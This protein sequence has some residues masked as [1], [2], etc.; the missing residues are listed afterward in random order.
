MDALLTNLIALAA[1][2][3]TLI[4]TPVA[5]AKGADV[6]ARIKA[7]RTVLGYAYGAKLDDITV[8]DVL[9][10]YKARKVT[11]LDYGTSLVVTAR[12][13][14]GAGTPADTRFVVK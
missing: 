13:G 14:R 3:G 6:L 9:A 5:L 12:Y 8:A 11:I 4:T 10:A 1:Y 2:F 7:G